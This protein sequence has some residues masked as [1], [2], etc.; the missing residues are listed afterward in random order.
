MGIFNHIYYIMPELI[1]FLGV[2]LLILIGAFKKD[3]SFA[4]NTFSVILLVLSLFSLFIIEGNNYAF[5]FLYY[6]SSFTRYMKAIVLIMSSLILMISNSYRVKNNIMMFEY[7]LLILFSVLGMLIM[8]S[9]NNIMSLYVSLEL[10]SLSLYVLVSIRRDSSKASEAGLKYFI[11]GSLA[12]AIILYGFSLIYAYTGKTN[13]NDISA[14]ISSYDKLPLGL[15]FGIIFSLSGVAFKLSAAP[16]HMWTP[17][18][19]EGSPTS[20]TTFLV[21]APK[22]AALAVLIRLLNEPFSGAILIWQQIIAAISIISM[23][24]GAVTALR[25]T[26]IKRLLAYGTIG[27][28]GY[29]FLGLMSAS[30]SGIIASVVFISLYAIMTIG[31]FSFIMA[32][33]KDEN[34]SYD[35]NDLAGLSKTHPIMALSFSIILISMASIPPL[36]GFVGKFYIFL[37]TVESGFVYLAVIGL[38]F[39]VISAFYYLKVIKIIYLDDLVESLSS[40]F[41]KR[42]SF[43]VFLSALFMLT[44]LLF[45]KSY[46]EMISN[47]VSSVF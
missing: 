21:T 35:I 41:D 11:L 19:Y 36:G 20:V 6:D 10:Q 46:V 8:I 30:E 24:I 3:Y 18:V 37:S 15:I 12:S 23:C 14:I 9:S 2:L 45:A 38:V 13:F 39:S 26:N 32:M 34:Q 40:P 33:R 28:M 31:A 47:S 22:I 27:N 25:Q 42:L 4:I 16:F 44:F 17:D 1:L 7:P 5:N 43:T 29:A